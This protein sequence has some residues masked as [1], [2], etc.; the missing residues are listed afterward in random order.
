MVVSESIMA[1][2]T[3]VY[4]ICC[5]T[6]ILKI[7]RCSSMKYYCLFF[8]CIKKYKHKYNL[9]NLYYYFILVI[10]ICN[11]ISRSYHCTKIDY[12]YTQVRLCLFLL[13]DCICESVDVFMGYNYSIT[14]CTLSV[15]ICDITAK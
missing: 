11:N 7:K 13:S 10:I 5:C 8:N 2:V 3:G 1:A 9:L 15:C 4:K 12:P 14:L 6:F